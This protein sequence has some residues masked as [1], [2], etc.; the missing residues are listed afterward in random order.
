MATRAAL[1]LLL[2]PFLFLLIV[3]AFTSIDPALEESSRTSGATAW[4]TFR[5][6]RTDG[7]AV[8]AAG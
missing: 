4:T 8:P 5:S 6:A 3:G 7:S 2:A 1:A